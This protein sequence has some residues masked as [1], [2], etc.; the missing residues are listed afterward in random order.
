MNNRIRNTTSS[1]SMCSDP[2]RCCKKCVLKQEEANL[3]DCQIR[4]SKGR[5]QRKNFVLPKNKT[6]LG[7]STYDV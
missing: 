6:I 1:E 4:W 2:S 5:K 3:G 7:T